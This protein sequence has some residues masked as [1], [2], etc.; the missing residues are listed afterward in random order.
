MI[1]SSDTAYVI[2][3]EKENGAA[4]RALEHSGLFIDVFFAAPTSDSMA[5]NSFVDLS[6]HLSYV[7]SLILFYRYAGL[8]KTTIQGR[9]TITIGAW[10]IFETTGVEDS[11]NIV[12]ANRRPS[13]ATTRH[14]FLSQVLVASFPPLS[15]VISRISEALIDAIG[16][17]CMR[18]YAT[19]RR[20]LS[21]RK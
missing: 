1:H 14:C 5:T 19:F 9:P 21:L 8:C 17:H 7:N 4:N 12:T 2:R 13:H 3:E 16:P 15:L 6:L 10:N 20:F 18:I 11:C